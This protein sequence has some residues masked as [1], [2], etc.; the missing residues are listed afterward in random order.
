MYSRRNSLTVLAVL[1]LLIGIG[2]FLYG[3]EEKAFA[4]LFK[5]NDELK[6]RLDSALEVTGSLQ[7]FEAGHRSLQKKWNQSSKRI[8]HA[9]E[10][11]FS[12]SYINWLTK[13]H[14]LDL[15]FD[16]FLNEKKEE[17]QFSTFSYTLTGEGNYRDFSS[18]VWY[19]TQYPLLYQIKDVEIK[20]HKKNPKLLNFTMLLEGYILPKD[21]AINEEITMTPVSLHWNRELVHDAFANLQPQIIPLKRKK[22]ILVRK[23]KPGLVNVAN[24]HLVAITTQKAYIRTS[25][26]K[27]VSLK[28]GDEVQYG[29][30]TRI[31][32]PMNQIEFLLETETGTK[33]VRLNLEYN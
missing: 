33:R 29:T 11:A 22:E 13:S 31:D 19:M 8:I 4:G 30:L 17:K 16:F 7:S 26:K 24:A 5:K 27:V 28:V 12:L 25:A 6:M 23:P 9:E 1:L 10:P 14:K 15:D 3:N 21:T 32:Q 2:Y 18:L 20:H